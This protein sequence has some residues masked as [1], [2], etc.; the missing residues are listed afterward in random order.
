MRILITGGGGQLGRALAAAY[1]SAAEVRAPGRAELDIADPARVRATVAGFRPDLIL[2]AGALTDVDGCET[3]H[4]DAFRANAFGPRVL[5]LAAAEHGTPLVHISTNFVFDGVK[6]PGETYHE[7]DPPAPLSVYGRSKLA[8]EEEVRRHAPRHVIVR[9]ALVYA[10]EGRNFVRTMLRLAGQDAP[11]RGV[12]DQW[13]QP[14]YAADLAVGIKALAATGVCGTYHLTNEGACTYR[15]WAEAIFQ[16]AG[17]AIAVEP[18]PA[19][20]FRRAAAIPANGVLTNWAAA[21]LGVTL[22]DWRDGLRRCLAEMGELRTE[23]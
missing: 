13:G 6:P 15:E 17:R 2:N 21:A 9:T 8:G 7:W 23:D 10:P 12:A 16:L 19:A 5:A 22:P 4:W 1:A 18:I 11:V 14:T 3:R 20:A